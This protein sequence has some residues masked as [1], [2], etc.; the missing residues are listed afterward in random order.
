MGV[1]LT[2]TPVGAT[3]SDVLTAIHDIIAHLVGGTPSGGSAITFANSWVGQFLST[4][5]SDNGLFFIP[6][7]LG[8]CLFGIHV[9]LSLMRR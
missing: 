8:L 3:M 9:L 5:V 2:S 6:F 1:F 4:I 7:V